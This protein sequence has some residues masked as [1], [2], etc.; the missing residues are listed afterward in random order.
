[1]LSVQAVRGLPRLRA[2]GIDKGIGAEIQKRD[3]HHGIVSALEQTQT[4]VHVQ[5]DEQ[6]VG[7]DWQPG[8]GVERAHRDHSLDD[9]CLN[10]I[11]LGFSG[12]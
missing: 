2:R 3:K 11:R 10:L 7:L 6:V 1:M 5:I 12:A 8:D 9:V 4:Q